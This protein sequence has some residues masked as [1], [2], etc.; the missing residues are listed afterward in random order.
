MTRK[1]SERLLVSIVDDD[2]AIRNALGNLLRSVGLGVETFASAEQFMDSPGTARRSC[3]VLDVQLP[4]MNGLELLRQL[5]GRP[6][7]VP[8]IFITA[9]PDESIRDQALEAGALGF[10]RKPF[11]SEALLNAVYSALK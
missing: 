10:F 3:V 2:E 7:A 6:N 5:S 4:R 9:H 11:S 8:V 1:K